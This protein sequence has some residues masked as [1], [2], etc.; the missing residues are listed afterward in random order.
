MPDQGTR[1]GVAIP[2][3]DG[4]MRVQR[5]ADREYAA[6]AAESSPRVL[7]RYTSPRTGAVQWSEVH[8]LV[9]SRD[10]CATW[11]YSATGWVVP[12]EAR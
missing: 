8:P 10:G 11:R 6:A 7:T 12:I 5:Y 4:V 3:G 1:W 2:V 9:H